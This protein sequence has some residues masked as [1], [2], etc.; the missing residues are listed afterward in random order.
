[1]MPPIIY[2]KAA[3]FEPGGAG[4]VTYLIWCRI[5]RWSA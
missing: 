1:M 5:G 3:A 2:I 4:L